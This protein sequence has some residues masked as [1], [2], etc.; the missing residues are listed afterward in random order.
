MYALGE[1]IMASVPNT[2]MFCRLECHKAM[3]T[4][5]IEALKMHMSQMCALSGTT[6][7]WHKMLHCPAIIISGV[8]VPHLALGDVL[9]R[10]DRAGRIEPLHCCCRIKLGVIL[11]LGE[12]EEYLKVKQKMAAITRKSNK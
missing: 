10:S 11:W 6:G 2:D 4:D 1:K 3:R 7:S 9:G 12:A 8:C 5:Q